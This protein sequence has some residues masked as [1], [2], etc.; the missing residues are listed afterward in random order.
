MIFIGVPNSKDVRD[1]YNASAYK[2]EIFLS[3]WS[4]KIKRIGKTGD[5]KFYKIIKNL[6][7]K[8]MF[9]LDVG[10]GTGVVPL[11]VNKYV[12]KVIGIDSSH[13]MISIAKD[14]I[15]YE[16]NIYFKVMDAFNLEFE[17]NSF[18]IVT[19]RLGVDAYKEMY[20]VLKKNGYLIDFIKGSNDCKEIRDLFHVQLFK[21]K[22]SLEN[23]RKRIEK[24]GFKVIKI[25][26]FLS[27][28]YLPDKDYIL[29]LIEI[30]PIIPD[31]NK[32]RD[33]KKIE[34]Y[35]EKYRRKGGIKMTREDVIFVCKAI[36]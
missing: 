26:N 2:R 22:Y 5:D 17:D 16:N 11:N 12:K 34:E 13:N 15:G 31:F 24:E 35:V 33:M 1:F 14:K 23:H 21:K 4:N 20:R 6:C 3:K 29:K 36:K 30:A 19:N 25:L 7:K 10:T 32:N 8:D 27:T 9:L 18:D 28:E